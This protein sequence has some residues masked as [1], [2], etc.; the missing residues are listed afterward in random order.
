[1]FNGFRNLGYL[2][3]F[4]KPVNPAIIANGGTI[5]QY[6]AN[7]RTNLAENPNFETNVS[8][9]SI[10]TTANGAT[11]PTQSAAQYHLG[12]KSA[13]INNGTNTSISI[14]YNIQNIVTSTGQYTF[15]IY[16]RAP[17]FGGFT[18]VCGYDF[19]GNPTYCY[20]P[21]AIARVE[22]ASNVITSLGTNIVTNNT[23]QRHSIT[24]NF[25]SVPTTATFRVQFS[26]L[27]SNTSIYIDSALFEKTSSLL[28]YFD[29]SSSDCHWNG[30]QNLSTS[31]QNTYN[32]HT[33]TSAGTFNVASLGTTFN[34]VDYLVV[35]GGGSGASGGGG[36][37]GMLLGTAEVGATAYNVTVG[38]GGTATS[39][40]TRGTS[41]QNSSFGDLIAIGGGAGGS[42]DPSG[43]H[44]GLNGGSG[45]GSAYPYGYMDG[46]LGTSG[47]GKN[48][49]ATRGYKDGVVNDGY[50]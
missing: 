28:D 6:P 7:P 37:G 46:G 38:A 41:G 17:Y 8:G 30:A 32:I 36:A 40:Q 35:G 20:V 34:T 42:Y 26:N 44:E 45:G 9:W 22:V 43:N 4:N 11:G 21:E 18:Y 31:S 12:T 3:N 29:G 49:G 16:L 25:T 10:S 2:D 27:N 48:G 13:L 23:W 5:T 1:M 19:M 14:S 33:F 15:S 24:V 47:Q 50:P 39:N